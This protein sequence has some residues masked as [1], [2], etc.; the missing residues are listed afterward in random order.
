MKKSKCFEEIPEMKEQFEDAIAALNKHRNCHND[1]DSKKIPDMNILELVEEVSNIVRKSGGIEERYEEYHPYCEELSARLALTEQQAYWLS[2]FVSMSDDNHIMVRDLANFIDCSSIR[3]QAKWEN[4]EALVRAGYIRPNQI[5]AT[6]AFCVPEKVMNSLR[7]NQAVPKVNIAGLSSEQLMDCFMDKLAQRDNGYIDYDSFWMEISDLMTA[8]PDLPFVKQYRKYNLSAFDGLILIITA[9]FCAS[10]GNERVGFG[11][12]M[13]ILPEHK[14]A[15]VA[16]R[17]IERDQHELQKRNLI[18]NQC[19]EGQVN[20]QI[21]HLTDSAKE[22]LLP[23]I[24]CINRPESTRGLMR[25]DTLQKKNL[26]FNADVSKSVNRLRTLFEKDRFST[27]QERLGQHG[28][29]KGFACVFYGAP[30]TGKTETVYQLARETGRDI[31]LVDVP[32]LRSKWVGDTEKNIKSVFDRYRALVNKS[33]IAPILL[34]NEADAVLTKRQ[35]GAVSGVDKMENA[36]QNI[37]LQEME[38]LNGIIIATTNLSGNLDAAFERRFLYKIEFPKPAPAER[39]YIW[40]NM[41]PG[42]SDENALDLAKSYD[43]SGG[44]IENIA[45]KQIIDSILWGDDKV[46]IQSINEACCVE[47]FKRDKK[48][49]PI[50]FA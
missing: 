38:N 2:I 20:S 34:F 44:Q 18:E 46:D 7:H 1:E 10:I 11:E 22:E 13:D 47:K 6:S 15:R 23:D 33:K 37:I 27:I 25:A 4:I 49:N 41:I 14:I 43:F 40:Q 19:E 36:M 28:M 29:R 8:N 32:N 17:Q 42:L 35:E 21:W 12:I 9:S 48:V 26:Y 3:V 30:G 16:M 5:D 31:L 45:R 24:E 39:R 50:G